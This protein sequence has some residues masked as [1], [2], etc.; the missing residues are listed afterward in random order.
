MILFKFKSF[1]FMFYFM[2]VSFQKSAALNQVHSANEL[3]L[4]VH[5]F[6]LPHVSWF[7]G[8]IRCWY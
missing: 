7:F 8:S 4:T 5:F 2:K 3:D 1:H 6:L